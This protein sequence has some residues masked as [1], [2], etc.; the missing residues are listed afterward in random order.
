MHTQPKAKVLVVDDEPN[1]LMSLEF[2][3]RKSGYEVFIARDGAEALQLVHEQHPNVLVLDVMMPQV[4]GYEVCQLIKSNP[5][6]EQIRVIF[7][8]AKSKET[9]IERGYAAGADLYL[10]KPFSTKELVKRIQEFL[11]Q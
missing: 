9:D 7:L 2:L 1:I 3:M 5:D 10:S 11:P 8:S 6:L 4:D